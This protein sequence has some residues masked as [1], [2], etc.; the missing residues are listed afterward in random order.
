MTREESKYIQ[1]LIK[2]KGMKTYYDN[3]LNEE[4][5]AL[6]FP[7]LKNG[8]G[9]L[10]LVVGMP[11]DLV[12][13][14][15]ELHTLEDMKWNHNHQ[16]P[17]K[18]WSWDITN[19]MTW[20][21]Q[22]P[23]YA[24]HPIY[25][26]QCCYHIDTPPNHI[27]TEMHTSDWWLETQVRRDTWALWCAN[28]RLVNAQ[29]GGYTGSHDRRFQQNA[30][31]EF[32]WQQDRVAW[33][34]DNCQSIFEAL[35]DALNAQCLNGCPS[36]VSDQEPQYSTETAASAGAYKPR[37]AERGTPAGTSASHL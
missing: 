25:A 29:S 15:W 20:L 13:W 18:Y 8:D 9:V 33:I 11:D 36:A 31:R 16:R 5:T 35:P 37:V 6:R 1:V 32:S 3:I 14:E 23:A 2:K 22:Q 30:S 24:E 21:M 19:S 27:D 7:S 17:I 12:L 34:Y 28:R 26:P 10:T 4:Y